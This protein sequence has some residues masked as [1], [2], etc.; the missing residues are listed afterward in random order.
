MMLVVGL[1]LALF[2]PRLRAQTA[3]DSAAIRGVVKD[4]ITAW[5]QGDAVAYSRHVATDATF[6]NIRGQFF[7]GHD[8]FLHQHEAI[9]GSFFKHTTLQQDIV[10]LRFLGPDVAVVEVLTAVSG[11]TAPRPAMTFDSHRRQRT[12]LLQVDARQAGEWKIVAYHNV[13][14]KPGVPVPDPR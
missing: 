11:V 14:V 2:A 3:A 5:N 12:R 1:S 13:D 9:F 6:T 7:T 8:A 4:E 10:A